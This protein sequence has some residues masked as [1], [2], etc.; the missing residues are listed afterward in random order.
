MTTAIWLL[1]GGVAA[2]MLAF[3]LHQITNPGKWT[4]YI[5]EFMKRSSPLA[6]EASMRLHALGNIA[7]GLF[8]V[9]GSFHPL[10]A[11]WVALIWWVSILPFAFQNKWDVGMRD[12]SIIFSLAALISLLRA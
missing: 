12:L 6:P 4:Q 7:F 11:A 10:L 3:G 1:R 2:T 5:P 9:A 8:L